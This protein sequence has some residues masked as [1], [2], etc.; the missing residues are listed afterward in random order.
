MYYK[1]L[2]TTRP[3]PIRLFVAQ[4]SNAVPAQFLIKDWDIPED[5]GANVYFEKPSGALIYNAATISGN[6]VTLDMTTQ[7]TAEQGVA[8]GQLEIIKG[9]IVYHSWLMEL[10]VLPTII[11]SSAIES[12]DE[13]TVLTERIAAAD[14]AIGIMRDWVDG[15]IEPFEYGA[16][17]YITESNSATLPD[18]W[19]F[20]TGTGGSAMW[21]DLSSG[22]IPDTVIQYG[23]AWSTA[24]GTSKR[25]QIPVSLSAGQAT[26]TLSC[27]AWT[28]AAMPITIEV[29][30]ATVSWVTAQSVSVTGWQKVVFTFIKT[31]T[32]AATITIT[33]GPDNTVTGAASVCGFQLEKCAKP[34]D[35]RPALSEFLQYKDIGGELPIPAAY[36]G[37]GADDLDDVTV[38]QA[39][40]D[41]AGNV[42]S[43]HYAAEDLTWSRKASIATNANNIIRNG[44]F[45]KT[46]SD[47]AGNNWP[48]FDTTPSHALLIV[49]RADETDTSLVIQTL[50]PVGGGTDA[51][52]IFHRSLLADGTAVSPWYRSDFAVP[53]WTEPGVSSG[54]ASIASGGFMKNGNHVHI[55]MRVQSLYTR[56]STSINAITFFTGLPAPNWQTPIQCI[57][58]TTGFCIPA[59]VLHTNG[60]LYLILGGTTINEGDELFLEGDYYIS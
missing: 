10:I 60:S 9:D 23:A 44:Y 31:S 28:S 18:G 13:F 36:G 41:A 30:G 21:V 7:M 22:S 1:E 49:A 25:L 33:I 35:W 27:Y 32:A 6:Y 3:E 53:Y 45:I 52:T 51:G 16:R 39:T 34:S 5:A 11:D 38:G 40:R 50:I 46:A 14:E 29:S 8:K 59:Y 20:E 15:F 24:S 19:S 4:G 56:T 58:A 47:L 48:T 43:T 37:T 26:Y 57:N 54:R 12:V 55:S 17:N 42:I 2:F